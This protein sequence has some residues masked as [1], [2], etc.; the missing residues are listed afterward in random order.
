MQFA[1]AYINNIV[2]ASCIFEDYITYL[3]QAFTCLIKY[4]IAIKGKKCFI[5]YLLAIILGYQVNSF[6][7]LTIKKKLAAIKN[8]SFL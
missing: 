6:K 5:S 3:K 2:I 4:N 1:K 7:L 8:L